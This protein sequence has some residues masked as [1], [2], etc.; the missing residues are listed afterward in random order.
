MSKKIAT[1]DFL[2]RAKEVHGNKYD[3][4][5]VDYK[6]IYEKICIICPKHG[7]FWQT[8]NNH[9][10]GK[11]CPLCSH[12]S[13][14]YSKE[15][16]IRHAIEIHK[17]KYDYSKVNYVNIRTKV[18]IICPKHGEFWQ[19]PHG[20]LEGRGCKKCGRDFTSNTQ[21]MGLNKFLKK[22]QEVHGD[23]YDYSKVEYINN[24]TKICIICPIHGEFWQTP[25]KH[26]QGHGCHKCNS[27]HLE[28]EIK[29]LLFEN[30]VN[31]E[32]EKN[33]DWLGL[34]RL[35][36]YLPQYN[37][38]IECQGEQH[39][40]PFD[41]FGGK[42]EYA[43]ILK[44]DERKR[45]LCEE[46]GIILLYYSNLHIDYPYKVYEDKEELLKEI[47]K[48]KIMNT[49]C[50]VY[51]GVSY[52]HPDKM[53]DIIADKLTDSFLN[54]DKN[55]RCGIEVII[56]DNVV[57][58]GGEV[59]SQATI[60][61][62]NIVRS[63]FDEIKFPT[64]H[65]LSPSNIKIINL[66]GKQSEEISQGVNK[67]DVGSGDQGVVWGFASKDTEELMPL[68]S[69]FARDLWQ[70]IVKVEG[71]GPDIKTQ[72]T[73]SSRKEI[74]EIVVST[75]HQIPL[76]EVK[77][78]INDIINNLIKTKY[79]NHINDNFERIIN[80]NGEWKIGGSVSDCGV[81][82]RKLVVDFYGASSPIGGGNLSGK[83]LSKV[84]R[85]GAYMARYL[86][87]NIVA[88]KL[89]DEAKVE[90]SYIISS[91]NPSNIDIELKNGKIDNNTLIK[92]IINNVDLTV[93]NMIEKF[94]N[95][96]FYETSKYGHF[97]NNKYPW[98]KTDLAEVLSN[99]FNGKYYGT[100]F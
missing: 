56:K 63:V 15:E 14:K 55:S 53:A 30:K 95:V 45:K 11:G 20:H 39:F 1:E 96:S 29:L 24:R 41:F 88:A 36:F 86:A 48:I 37:I 38:A 5:K 47:L 50:Y 42:E 27:S 21:K 91:P 81:T 57:V 85:S 98:E 22:S 87:K 78:I 80:L 74:K 84:D 70:E 65:N 73:V 32:E 4:S 25:Y 54:E 33:F 93:K 100:F 7:E 3:Y 8:P 99:K 94:S 16:F 64:N 89:A 62:D 77:N 52:G 26:L 58:L 44:R 2:K 28:N 35:D 43:K 90:L 31:F 76:E 19:T 51:E 92:W 17:K 75:M 83:D 68:G 67:E 10:Q 6:G 18:C 71:L 23:K 60:D 97:G 59:N 40:K 49:K 72:V 66:I 46:H 12:R 79:S 61:Y 13:Y 9:L 69:Q 34:Q 82:G